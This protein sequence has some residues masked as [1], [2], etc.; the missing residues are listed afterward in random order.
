MHNAILKVG[1]SLSASQY[2]SIGLSLRFSFQ[3]PHHV[4]TSASV[5][6]VKVRVMVGL[7]SFS[8]AIRC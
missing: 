5:G 4:F 8:D 3:I 1:R 6:S 2:R 7:E